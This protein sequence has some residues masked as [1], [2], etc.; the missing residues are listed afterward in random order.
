MN[1][2]H[3]P[4]RDNDLELLLRESKKTRAVD[5]RRTARVRAAVHAEWSATTRTR[6]R[7][8]RWP[9]AIGALATAAAVM[10][11]VRPDPQPGNAVASPAAAPVATVRFVH[12]GVQARTR[13]DAALA[14]LNVGD[15]LGVGVV[16]V[17]DGDGAGSVRLDTGVDVR[18]GPLTEV[19]LESTGR[20]VLR[21]GRLYV[22]TAGRRGPDGGPT[23]EVAV[24]GSIVRDIGTRFMVIGDATV[25]VGVR[26]GLVELDRDGVIYKAAPGEHLAV[27]AE[28]RVTTSR[29]P[30]FGPDWD[31]I[32]RAAPPQA[33]DGR[34]LQEFLAW[35]EREG[36]R[37][38]R[39]ADAA[40]GQSTRSTVVYGTIDGLTVDEALAVV[41]PTCGLSH[42]VD[43]GVITVVAVDEPVRLR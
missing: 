19:T 15:T 22:D 6:T 20:L 43:D 33:V 1:V 34:T 14:L 25:S 41:L 17:A 16:V 32:V 11:A 21:R 24:A 9:W 12:G 38:V 36:G 40:L 7:P 23:L 39:F 5:A 18:V 3:D 13:P 31:W 35:V 30:L 10:F 4:T 27:S 29:R 28:G 26:D 2:P 37:T 8:N 42:R